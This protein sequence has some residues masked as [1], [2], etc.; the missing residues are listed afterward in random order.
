MSGPNSMRTH[1]TTKR[2]NERKVNMKARSLHCE[3]KD[4]DPPAR[5]LQSV[6]A[7]QR[8]DSI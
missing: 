7:E 4:A 5:E 8:E 3:T 2:M 6:R 1:K